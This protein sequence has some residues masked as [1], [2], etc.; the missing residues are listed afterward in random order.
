MAR[1]SIS[2]FLAAS[3]LIAGMAGCGQPPEPG[4]PGTGGAQQQIPGE[5][6]NDKEL[7][8]R[9]PLDTHKESNKEINKDGHGAEG[10]EGGEGGEG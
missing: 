6:E 7:D 3:G 10:G 9:K 1:S 2:L 4:E 5:G 8:T